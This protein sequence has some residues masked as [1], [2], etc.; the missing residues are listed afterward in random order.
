M[1]TF[2]G[3]MKLKGKTLIDQ[4][5]NVGYQDIFRDIQ[6]MREAS[7]RKEVARGEFTSEFS[8]LGESLTQTIQNNKLVAFLLVLGGFVACKY[9][10]LRG[11]K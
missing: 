11:R 9:G 2:P 8:G 10:F 1:N 3:E 5:K 6:A 4:A 7:Y